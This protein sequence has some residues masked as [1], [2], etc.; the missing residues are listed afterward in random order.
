MPDRDES[1]ESRIEELFHA[2]LEL[3]PAQREPYL[4]AQAGIDD[5]TR[6]QVLEMIAIADDQPDLLEPPVE[7]PAPER[8]GKYEIL[9]E[10]GRGGMGVVY[11]ARDTQLGRDVAVKVLPERLA[12]DAQSLERFEREACLLGA[13]SNE[14]IA[15]LYSLEEDGGV[16]FLTMEF[17]EGR[18]LAAVLREGALPLEQTLR[19]ARQVARA[20][21]AAHTR[22]IVHRDLKPANIMITAE[23]QAKVLDFGI[24]KALGAGPE[25][26]ALT[27]ATDGQ[28]TTTFGTPGYMS[29]EQF[30]GGLVD[31]RADIWAFGCLL[32]ECLTGMRAVPS[33]ATVPAA[34]EAFPA[35]DLDRLPADLPSQIR[36]LL[37]DCLRID[38]EQRLDSAAAICETL[39]QIG[40]DRRRKSA[41]LGLTGWTLVT[42]VVLV[43]G[44]LGVRAISDGTQA[45]LTAEA[46]V[47]G[48]AALDTFAVLIIRSEPDEAVVTVGGEFAGRAPLSLR[49][50]SGTTVV[51]AAL[52]GYA[53]ATETLASAFGDT[54]EHRF[55]LTELTG[56]LLVGS[57]PAGAVIVLDGRRLPDATPHLIRDL[58]VRAK[59]HVRLELPGYLDGDLGA[60]AVMADTTI[61]VIHQ[62]QLTSHPLMIY[63]RPPGA[64]VAIDGTTVAITPYR[65]PALARGTHHVR[66]QLAGYVTEQRRFTVPD[67][68][69]ILDVTL[70]PLPPGILD[71]RI[72]RFADV[73]I[74][75]E[76]R[77]S[78][79]DH[80]SARFAP[81]RHFIELRHNVHPAIRDTVVIESGQT[82]QKR[83]EFPAGRRE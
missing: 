51:Q 47:A 8:L 75:G 60:I 2:L 72:R 67:S 50:P 77:S 53:A 63:S 62:F 74:D 48:S 3:P 23:G 43:A 49:T 25:G 4:A 28:M 54:V 9:A 19:V 80:F 35:P 46:R 34:G 10:T 1:T 20:L 56:D 71:L 22:R 76:K 55:V 66:F 64:T 52:P 13:L 11:R 42:V 40:T 29:P 58:S 18:T 5:D 37:A 38:P 78:G 61:S 83:Y 39:D 82:L 73:W 79:T 21:S 17:V 36:S 30:A 27:T 6:V 45:G 41:G 81:G 32:Y 70:E 69:E 7:P 57:E 31:R 68:G 65:L 12:R 59:H 15:T 16:R 14:N 26:R 33:G 24:A 44:Y